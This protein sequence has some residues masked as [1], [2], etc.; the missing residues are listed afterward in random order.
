MYVWEQRGTPSAITLSA[1]KRSGK[2]DFVRRFPGFEELIEE[3]IKEMLL[4]F[5]DFLK[6][7]NGDN[8]TGTFSAHMHFPVAAV[9]YYAL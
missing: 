4:D 5:S 9:S 6:E 3:A 2:L 1:L 8:Y 7:Y